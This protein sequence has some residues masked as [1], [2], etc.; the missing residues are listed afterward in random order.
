[1]TGAGVEAA[2]SALGPM[3]STSGSGGGDRGAHGGGGGD[4]GASHH[5]DPAH[6]AISDAP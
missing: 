3:S 1:M 5:R 6:A 2:W 4:G